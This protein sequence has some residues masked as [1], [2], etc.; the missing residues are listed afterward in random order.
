[1][2]IGPSEIEKDLVILK[3]MKTGEQK[4]I[5]TNVIPNLF[6]DLIK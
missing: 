6:R 2:I 1:V 3:D 4:E 5:K